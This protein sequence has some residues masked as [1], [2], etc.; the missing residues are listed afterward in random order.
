MIKERLPSLLSN[1]DN[2]HLG[3]SRKWAPLPF[4][5]PLATPHSHAK[6]KRGRTGVESDARPKRGQKQRPWKT[7]EKCLISIPHKKGEDR[8]DMFFFWRFSGQIS[9]FSKRLESFKNILNGQCGHVL[10][11]SLYHEKS[12]FIMRSQ[13]HRLN[14]PIHRH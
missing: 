13:V 11:S 2:L 14:S 4:E 3:S 10:C 1:G 9:N 12:R 7:L 6:S 8:S 5:T